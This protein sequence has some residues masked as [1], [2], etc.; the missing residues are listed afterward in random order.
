MT[1]YF[2]KKRKAWIS[3]TPSIKVNFIVRHCPICENKIYE[4]EFTGY[5][6]EEMNKTQIEMIWNDKRIAILCCNCYKLLEKIKFINFSNYPKNTID[7][8]LFKLIDNTSPCIVVIKNL[9]KFGIIQ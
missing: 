7:T 4:C 8:E 6:C 1:D 5:N 2:E 3:C 9:K